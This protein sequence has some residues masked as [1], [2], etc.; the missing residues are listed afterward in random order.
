MKKRLV[1][2]M[3]GVLSIPF[4]SYGTEINWSGFASI[5]GGQTLDSETT[6]DV[7]FLGYDGVY[8]DELSIN[9]DTMFGL[10]ANVVADEKLSATVQLIGRG[11]DSFDVQAEWAYVS[12][13]LSEEFTLNA[14]RYRLP[15]F[16][17][18]DFLD[19]AYTYHWVRP[20]S[21]LYGG[22]SF[23]DGVNLYYSTYFGDYEFSSQLSYGNWED[24]IINPGL[25]PV[26]QE[27]NNSL[28]FNALFGSDLLKVR[29]VYSVADSIIRTTLPGLPPVLETDI[30]FWGIALIGDYKNILL[31]SE[32]TNLELGEDSQD[33]GYVSVGYQVNSLTPHITYTTQEALVS[34]GRPEF[35]AI[36]YGLAWNF[37]SSA[38]LKF[39]YQSNDYDSEFIGDFDFISFGID[40]VF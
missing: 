29:G 8:D 33:S 36:T 7:G 32:F 23:I 15:L 27:S 17:Y 13:K 2:F 14:G 10:Q 24:D 25:G 18:S 40:M 3:L 19:V 6:F 26:H 5:I 28:T 4:Q 16:Y 21:S 35:D 30:E 34:T 37:H 12:Y 1:L 9:P 38:V 20:P 22:P 11:G 39:E 31:R